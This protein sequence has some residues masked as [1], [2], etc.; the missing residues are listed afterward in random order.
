MNKNVI[1]TLCNG[2]VAMN[3]ILTKPHFFFF[4]MLLTLSL[5]S[6]AT[7]DRGQ[8]TVGTASSQK[9]DNKEEKENDSGNNGDFEPYPVFKASEILT[10]ELLK[11][12]HYE[13]IEEVN[14]DCIWNSYTIKSDYGV[15]EAEN[16]DVLETRVNEINATA[17]LKAVSPGQAL[18]EGAVDSVINPFRAAINIASN[19]VDTAKG[20]PGGIVTFFKKI[21]YS[22]EKV[23]VV[24][25]QTVQS[26]GGTIVSSGSD[27]NGQT[28][29][30]ITGNVGYLTD[31]YL[32][33]SGG[34][35]RLAKKLR[36]D[37]YTSNPELAAE[38]NRVAKYDRLGRLGFGF[39]DTPSVPGMGYVK[40]VN[41]YVWDK[42]P[43]ELRDFNRKNLLEMGIDADLIEQFLDSP[44]YSP[45]F[46]T[47]IV[48]SLLQLPDVKN[49]EEIIEDAIV[50]SSISESKFFTKI[51]LLL[52]WYNNTQ[53][54]LREI[55][56]HGDI[57]S[58]LNSDNR[59]VTIIPVDYVCWSEQVAEAANFH[60]EVFSGV[61]T[62][63]KELWIIG[64][65]SE[66]ATLGFTNLGWEVKG[67]SSI[68]AVTENVE[69]GET[70]KQINQ[71][72][73]DVFKEENQNNTPPDQ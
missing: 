38:L 26:V 36:V 72:A 50:A 37:P 69:K 57:T 56:N 34:E 45:T 30:D 27:E 22:G 1:I 29:S 67:Q 40:D 49:R 12:E 4:I 48:F 23:V 20:V 19:P 14:N 51:V 63:G 41:H 44:Y 52:V 13:V 25:G 8:Q 54:P 64:D 16:T 7:K 53:L 62:R 28:F 43:K 47:A 59:I 35:R 71:R 65:I 33:I 15:Y 24:T 42:D 18:A 70:T 46:Q 6:C 17:S 68:E 10:P 5:C 39:A 21:Y 60:N 61:D 2:A 32:G 58:G 55:I 31:W 9:S 66:R 3:S 73:F 11:G